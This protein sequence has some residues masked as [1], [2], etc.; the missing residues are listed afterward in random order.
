MTGRF[1]YCYEWATHASGSWT[2]PESSFIR[3]IDV[4]KDSI[5]RLD[6]DG[7]GDLRVYKGSSVVFRA[8]EFDS[9]LDYRFESGQYT[10][11]GRAPNCES[12]G[13]DW[14]KSFRIRLESRGVR[15][16]NETTTT[17]DQRTGEVIVTTIEGKTP[18]LRRIGMWTLILIAPPIRYII[19]VSAIYGA[20]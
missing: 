3:Q 18:I 5:A 10:L 19:F 20:Q 17:S 4:S 15:M 14:S 11:E 9:S 7:L 6:F 2:D 12:V 13:T 16:L 1:G 8:L